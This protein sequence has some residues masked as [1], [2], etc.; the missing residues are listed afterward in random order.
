MRDIESLPFVFRFGDTDLVGNEGLFDA[1]CPTEYHILLPSVQP[2]LN[3]S[4][5]TEGGGQ[6]NGSPHE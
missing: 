6:I 3:G 2:R 5:Q 1:R 4:Y